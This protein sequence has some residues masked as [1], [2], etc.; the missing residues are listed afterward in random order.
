M[1]SAT[2]IAIS[3]INV[4]AYPILPYLVYNVVAYIVLSALSG[5]TKKVYVSCQ[6]WKINIS[7]I[8]VVYV[9]AYPIVK[10]VYV[11]CQ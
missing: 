4:G 1:A 9:D 2:T 7:A 8:S 5:A 3:V 6:E 11:L 10:K